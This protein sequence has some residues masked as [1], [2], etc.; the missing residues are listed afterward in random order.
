MKNRGFRLVWFDFILGVS[1]QP[2][3]ASQMKEK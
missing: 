3:V 2:E 1:N